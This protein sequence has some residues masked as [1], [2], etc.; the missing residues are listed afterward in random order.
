MTRHSQTSRR[1]AAPRAEVEPPDSQWVPR[2]M[3]EMESPFGAPNPA[4]QA[5]LE[6][7]E[8]GLLAV[9][10]M[11]MQP[12]AVISTQLALLNLA[13][14]NIGKLQSDW[15]EAWGQLMTGPSM[16]QSWLEPWQALV[17]AR[18]LQIA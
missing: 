13:V 15:I 12:M 2:L 11:A 3:H 4:F 5:T 17:T 14:A 16:F 1:R 7:E 18:P 8:E 9:A 10:R 6:Q